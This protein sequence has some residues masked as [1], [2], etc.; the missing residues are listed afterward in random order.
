MLDN[1][2]NFFLVHAAIVLPLAVLVAL[3][4]SSTA[5][6]GFQ[7]LLR[8]LSRPLLIA[9]VVALAY[10]GTR[11]LAGGSGM[12]VTSLVEHWVSFSPATFEAFKALLAAKVH[13]QAWDVAL[14]PVLRLPAW[15]LAGGLGLLLAWLGRRRK[16]VAIFIN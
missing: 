10:D 3:G 14:A 13:P 2:V 5:R 12:V 11:T 9:A 1:I 15:L 16:E 7:A 4:V 8:F 6:T